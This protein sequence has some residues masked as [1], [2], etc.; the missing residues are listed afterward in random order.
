VCNRFCILLSFIIIV[1]AHPS[2][3]LSLCFLRPHQSCSALF[4][5][6]TTLHESPWDVAYFCLLFPLRRR[7]F[8]P[9]FRFFSLK[10]Q[11][12]SSPGSMGIPNPFQSPSPHHIFL[13]CLN[14]LIEVF[15]GVPPFFFS[16]LP[17]TFSF[18]R[19]FFVRPT[20]F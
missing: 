20:V 9:F 13:I 16:P 5:A 8:L 4:P 1:G 12:P 11:K 10:P 15:P 2:S 14:G 6:C 3:Q 18:N 19:V 7:V 17:L